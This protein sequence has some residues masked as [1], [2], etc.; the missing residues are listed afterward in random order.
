MLRIPP[1][2]FAAALLLGPSLG[3]AQVTTVDEGSFTITRGGVAAGRED[4]SIRSSVAS[5]TPALIAQARIT[6]G[7]RQVSPG[8]NA[9]TSG[10]VLRYQDEVRV[11]G[12]VVETYSGQNTRDHYSARVH[13]EGGESAREFRLP[14]G[15]VAADDGVV[16][17]LWFIV[18]R[19]EG[20][21]VPVL[22]PGRNVVEI[23]RV[24]V[25]GHETLTFDV[26]EIQ[27]IHLRLRTEGTGL[28]R[29]VWADAA[30][31]V[32]KVAIQA[33]RMVAIRNF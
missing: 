21:A 2:A 6:A 7:N 12:R 18:R 16:H 10:F 25:A 3:R 33:E 22:V 1:A 11:D 19:G 23:V 26:R 15:T 13:R 9:D 17:Q 5:G 27:A 32:L 4:F 8:L 28:V 31:R 14:P 24:E 29:D 30:G 20:A